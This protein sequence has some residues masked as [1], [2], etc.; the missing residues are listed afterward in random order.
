MSTHNH[1]HRDHS[2]AHNRNHSAGHQ[3]RSKHW[4]RRTTAIAVTASFGAAA[5]AGLGASSAHAAATG[6]L[7]VKFSGVGAQTWTVPAGVTSAT[8]TGYGAQGGNTLAV[9]DGLGS[10]K[11][12]MQQTTLSGLTPGQTLQVNVGGRGTNKGEAAVGGVLKGGF[13]GGGDANPNNPSAAGGGASDVRVDANSDGVY[14]LSERLAVAGGAGGAGVNHPTSTTVYGYGGDGGGSVGGD[15]GSAYGG[16]GGFGGRT[17]LDPYSGSSDDGVGGT[18]DGGGGGGGSKGGHP[19]AMGFGGGGGSS[20]AT[21][22]GA[23]SVSDSSTQTG[24]SFTPATSTGDG[25]IEIN[26]APPNWSSTGWDNLG[27]TTNPL[28]PGSS[29]SAGLGDNYRLLAM[30]GDG[31]LVMS[32]LA[33]QVIWASNTYGNNGAK[34]VMDNGQFKI[35]NAAGTTTLWHAFT[36]TNTGGTLKL[37]TD[38]ILR[39]DNSSGSNPT[40]WSTGFTVTGN[41][42]ALTSGQSVAGQGRQTLMQTDGNLVTYDNAYNVI[43]STNTYGNNGAYTIM[44]GGD[45]Q[46]VGS[47]GLLWHTNTTTG[48][49]VT[50]Q[51]DSNIILRNSSNAVIWDSY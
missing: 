46:I 18:S 31:N 38:G 49:T 27:T 16:Y 22:V 5:V 36:A 51:G 45:L 15:A 35:V 24:G 10:A 13:N 41:A 7:T 48:N 30:Q 26:Y 29:Y 40:R 43:W 50:F 34:A 37:G 21:T 25:K 9:G 23:I 44:W 14:S 4:R 20:A 6:P 47:N 1:H 8:F 19:G 32:N 17:G 28:N 12:G 2:P 11:G 42:T 33:G 39:A 3:G